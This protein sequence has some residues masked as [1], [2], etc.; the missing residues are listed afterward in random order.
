VTVRATF[1]S[2]TGRGL[3]NGSARAQVTMTLVWAIMAGAGFTLR[4]ELPD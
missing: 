4:T 1:S 3:T 2:C